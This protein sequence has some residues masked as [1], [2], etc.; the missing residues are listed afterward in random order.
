M[1]VVKDNYRRLFLEFPFEINEIKLD[2]ADDRQ[3]EFHWHNFF[4]ITYIKKGTITYFVNEKSYVVEA[5]DFAIFNHI[6]PHGWE[7]QGEEAEVLVMVFSSTFISERESG[8][9]YDYLK[10]FIERGSNFQNVIWQRDKVVDKMAVI[11]QE[12]YLEWQSRA[13]GYKLMIKA[14]VLK[15]LTL[16]TRYYT[17]DNKPMELLEQKQ[18]AMKR[19]EPIFTYMYQY[20][21]KKITLDE[22]AALAYMSPTYFS[23]FFRKVTGVPF[24]E[25]LAGIRIREVQR[26][27]RN[28]DA[29][30]VDIALACGFH[31]IS[32]FYRIYKKYTGKSPGEERK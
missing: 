26:C 32:N 8:F 31:N 14:D 1:K 10:P 6:E 5:G 29:G 28:Q 27:L 16:L 9:D 18:K 7:I 2:K 3:E 24:S 23:A 4:E 21:S 30:I 12:V 15:L 17:D 20:Y 19:L 22:M 11:M 13:A 25:Y